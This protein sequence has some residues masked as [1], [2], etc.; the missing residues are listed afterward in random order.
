MSVTQLEFTAVQQFAHDVRAGLGGRPQK[1]LPAQYFYDAVGSALF[2]AITALPEYGLTRSDARLLSKH[3]DEI[4]SGSAGPLRVVELGSGSGLKTRW[5]LEA[6]VRH[7]RPVP[8]LPIDVSSSALEM[9]AA[10]L[11]GIDGV[12][13]T[14]LNGTYLEGLRDAVRSRKI[15]ER[16]LVLFLGSTIGNFSPQEAIEFLGAVRALLEPGDCLLLGADLIKP[17]SQLLA[18]YD[19]PTGVTAAFNLNLL[20]RINRELDAD[21]DLRSFRHVARFNRSES[22]VEMHLQSTRE[23]SVWVAALNQRFS[24]RRDETIW[25][26]SSYKFELDGL[27]KLARSGGFRCTGQWVDEEWPFAENLLVAD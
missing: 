10:A 6:A 20:G 16:V 8:Y 5:I 9:C 15:R 26:E 21:F 22:R 2:E 13:V 18:A 14:A 7:A 27:R 4:V 11:G 19:D 24:F 17:L 1:T 12:D 3:S 23:Q 25:T